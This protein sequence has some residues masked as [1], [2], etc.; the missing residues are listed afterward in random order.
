M[1]AQELNTE[2]SGLRL[3]VPD[4]SRDAP[5]GVEWLHGAVGRETLGLMGVAEADNTE[6]T[7]EIETQRITKM[8]ESESEIAWMLERDG[9]VVGVIEVRLQSDEH[10]PAPNVSTMIGSPGARGQGVG[11][12]AKQAVIQYMFHERGAAE[13]YSRHLTSNIVSAAGLTKLGFQNSG[14]IYRDGDGLE[15]QNKV[16]RN[17]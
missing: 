10:L 2:L 13:L 4:V 12:A 8:I 5:N 9:V 11:T 3:I 7:L 15:W 16:L 14:D 1:T 6:S 17:E